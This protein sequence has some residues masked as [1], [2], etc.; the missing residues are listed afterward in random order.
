MQDYL[1]Y[2]REVLE[3]PDDGLAEI[4]DILQ[5]LANAGAYGKNLRMIARRPE[6][7]SL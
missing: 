3:R 7:P 5:F 4:A 2:R 6:R 1:W